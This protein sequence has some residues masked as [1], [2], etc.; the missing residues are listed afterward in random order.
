[1]LCKDVLVE[2][3]DLI[4]MQ[5]H[6]MEEHEVSQDALKNVTH[7]HDSNKQHY[8]YS[9]PDGRLWMLARRIR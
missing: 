2:S 8:I 6:A 4:K 9:L 5:E 3:T 1:M 7:V